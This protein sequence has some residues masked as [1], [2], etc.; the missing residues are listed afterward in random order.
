M[1]KNIL[2][3]LDGSR[4]AESIIACVA[5]L[6]NGFSHEVKTRVTLLQ[7][8]PAGK[9]EIMP[10]LIENVPYSKNEKQSFEARSKT[11]LEA[12][13]AP[14]KKAGA[15]IATVLAYGDPVKE[16]VRAAEETK[17]DMIAMSTHGRS[18]LSRLAFG[19]VADG[20]LRHETGIPVL[21]IR[22]HAL[23]D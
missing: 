1:N 23:K 20:V 10:G 8:L 12:A 3:P 13:A 17:A 14:L 16:I 6:L 18:G 21:L 19:N 4:T 7:V 2:I 15:E 11:Y 9:T 22:A 5:D